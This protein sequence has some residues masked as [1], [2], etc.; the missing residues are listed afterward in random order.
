M[1]RST[2]PM[3]GNQQ[4]PMTDSQ[5]LGAE[6]GDQLALSLDDQKCGTADG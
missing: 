4:A 3:M 2:S 6:D 1:I 5:K